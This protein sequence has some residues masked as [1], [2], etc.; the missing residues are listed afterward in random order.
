MVPILG[1]ITWRTER[2][3]TPVVWPGEFHGLYG[4]CQG[5]GSHLQTIWGARDFHPVA[6]LK[7]NDYLTQNQSSSVLLGRVQWP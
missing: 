7:L 5:I 1:K 2:L 4:P 3:P 6:L